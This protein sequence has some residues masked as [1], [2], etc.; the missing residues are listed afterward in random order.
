MIKIILLIFTLVSPWVHADDLLPKTMS[1]DSV[2]FNRCNQYTLR[3]GF[4]IKVAEIG[5]YAPKCGVQTLLQ[6]NNKI[7]R[8]HYYKDVKADFFIKSAE[9][10]FLLNLENEAQE[11]ALIE[12]LKNFNYG[13]TDIQSGEYFQL[14]HINESNLSLYKN[15]EL[16][17]STDNVDLAKKYFNIWFGQKPVIKKLKNAFH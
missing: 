9:K 10:Y 17:A 12:P 7:L 13:Y 14:V 2:D 16:L 5:W 6:T 4:V 8:F 15:E 11:M 3:Y 1:L